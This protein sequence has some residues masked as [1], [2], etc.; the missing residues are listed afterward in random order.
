MIFQQKVQ[1]MS[2][3]EFLNNDKDSI[4]LKKGEKKLLKKFQME[5]QKVGIYC[6]LGFTT[7]TGALVLTVSDIQ[8]ASA[9]TVS[10]MVHEKI[11]NA[12]MPLVELI[13]GLSYPIA[14]IIMS[15]G[16]LMLMLGNKE[17]G[18]SMIQNASIGYILVQMMP[19]LMKLLVEIAKAM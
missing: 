17:K 13:K 11:T 12:F 9:A 19:L 8:Y 6:K 14:L 2:I 1:T 10:G 7:V 18:Y 15:C 3:K 5:L 4:V 16:A